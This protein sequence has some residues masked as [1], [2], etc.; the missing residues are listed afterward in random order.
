MGSGPDRE[1]LLTGS[2]DLVD[3]GVVEF[4]SAGLE[5]LPAMAAADIGVLLADPTYH[6]EGCSNTIME[7]M[8]CGLPVV[9]TDS[10]GN[11]ELVEDGVT[12]TLVPP[13]D[14]AALVAALRALRHDPEKAGAMGLA[15]TGRL[16]ALFS[17]EAMAAGFVAAYQY[18][19]AERGR[20]RT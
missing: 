10:G 7:Y 1:A 9:C 14:V 4:P 8:A 11:P 18:V 20:A 16:E 12:G 13:R 2:A 3:R 17:V 15:G 5:A 6:A 19:L